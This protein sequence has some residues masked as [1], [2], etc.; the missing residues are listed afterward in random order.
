ME[1]IRTYTTMPHTPLRTEQ[2]LVLTLEAE[3]LFEK[4]KACFTV[5]T[6]VTSVSSEDLLSHPPNFPS[7]NHMQQRLSSVNTFPNTCHSVLSW[8]VLK[9]DV[10]L[11]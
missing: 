1:E 7:L 4:R 3:L 9:Q 8:E 11:C 5:N 10:I 6:A 2:P